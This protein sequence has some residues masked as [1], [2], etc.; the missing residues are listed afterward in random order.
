MANKSIRF[1]FES[2]Y[3]LHFTKQNICICAGKQ[4]TNAEYALRC[5]WMCFSSLLFEII[6][7]AS[8]HAP[9]EMNNG[10]GNNDQTQQTK[11]K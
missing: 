1:R 7:F 5:L 9:E 8:N 10:N 11:A 6:L 2:G 4:W 3:F